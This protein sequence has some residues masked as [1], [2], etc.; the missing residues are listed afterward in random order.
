[1]QEMG[2]INITIRPVP[3]AKLQAPFL[4]IDSPCFATAKF[5][6]PSFHGGPEINIE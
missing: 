3:T 6:A 4:A 5:T 2:L 1:M